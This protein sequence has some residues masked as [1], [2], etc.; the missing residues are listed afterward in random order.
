MEQ[1]PANDFA[2]LDDDLGPSRPRQE[3][4]AE[5]MN[6]TTPVSHGGSAS[7]AASSPNTTAGGR[8]ASAPHSSLV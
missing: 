3:T 2:L 4:P 8:T 7:T 5:R 6:N 1:K